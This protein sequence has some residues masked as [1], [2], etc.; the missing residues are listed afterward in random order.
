VS[1][2][3]L[4]LSRSL[5]PPPLITKKLPATLQQLLEQHIGHDLANSNKGV[6]KKGGTWKSV[7]MQ[8]S[9]RSFLYEMIENKANSL[10]GAFDFRHKEAAR[11]LDEERGTMTV[12]QYLT[13]KKKQEVTTKKRR[14]TPV[15]GGRKKAR[16]CH[17]Y[18]TVS[19]LRGVCVLVRFFIVL[20][21][22]TLL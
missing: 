13:H 14:V 9:R 11:R 21:S 15:L 12:S 16:T 8:L 6:A 19:G 2:R 4:E 17:T 3:T 5:T 20:H 22:S 7:K 18:C 10:R 1:E